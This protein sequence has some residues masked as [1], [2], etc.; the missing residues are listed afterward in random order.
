M[1][2]HEFWT[3]GVKVGTIVHLIHI[4]L[5]SL[6]AQQHRRPAGAVR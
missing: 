1:S 5:M 6:A 3:L 4:Q 2:K